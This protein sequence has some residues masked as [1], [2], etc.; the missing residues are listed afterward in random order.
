MPERKDY[1]G[2]RITVSYDS[3]RCIHFAEC[4]R[5]LPAVFD[6]KQRPWIQVDQADAKLV[7]EVVR[8]CP[9]GALHYELGG[10]GEPESPDS[11]TTVEPVA[12]GPLNLRGDLVIDTP[13]G[14]LAE[15]RAS[16]CRCGLTGNQPFC[17]HE[18][19]RAG[20]KSSS[21]AG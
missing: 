5:G 9:S 3:S 19:Q 2:E 18:C 17:D 15:T 16:L 6:V 7:A 13:Q 21:A 12:D 14:P 8:R 4:V 11:P 20:W 10:D 1:T